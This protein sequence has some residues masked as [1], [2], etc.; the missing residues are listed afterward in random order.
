MC[1]AAVQ[2]F[3]SLVHTRRFW[4]C[5]WFCFPEDIYA[6]SLFMCQPT[7]HESLK[8]FC[9]VFLTILSKLRSPLLLA[10]LFLSHCLSE[11][12]SCYRSSSMVFPLLMINI[13]TAVERAVHRMIAAVCAHPNKKCLCCLSSNLIKLKMKRANL[14]YFDVLDLFD[15]QRFGV[16][17]V[18]ADKQS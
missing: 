6:C 5:L 16:G 13:W 14:R 4:W 10:D 15:S 9:R 12:Q 8:F 7:P 11:Q 17:K 3:F 18:A 2:F 1:N